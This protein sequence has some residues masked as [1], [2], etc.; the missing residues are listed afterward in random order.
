MD[1]EIQAEARRRKYSVRV[2]RFSHD[3]AQARD[4]RTLHLFGLADDHAKVKFLSFFP[5]MFSD[6][7][8]GKP[9]P[10]LI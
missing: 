6:A 9:F 10:T 4:R 8:G 3:S 1:K 5:A 7:C 2:T